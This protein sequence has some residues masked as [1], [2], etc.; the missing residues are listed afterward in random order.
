M[1]YKLIIDQTRERCSPGP[2]SYLG[3]ILGVSRLSLVEIII[4]SHVSWLALAA[5]PPPVPR[6]S[7]QTGLGLGRHAIDCPPGET[8]G[9]VLEFRRRRRTKVQK[10]IL[11]V[12]PVCVWSGGGVWSTNSFTMM[13]TTTTPA[14]VKL[15]L[16]SDTTSAF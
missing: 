1:G 13:T 10:L 11:C 6:T 3:Q 16:K 4:L 2:A 8:S 5:A 15:V 12:P 9:Q 7:C 14:V